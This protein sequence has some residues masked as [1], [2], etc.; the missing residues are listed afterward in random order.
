VVARY[1]M[2]VTADPL[3]T[4]E[5]FAIGG[6]YTVRGYR[7][8]QLVR[9]NG[10][11]GSAEVR[12]P[13]YARAQPRFRIDLIPFFD[14]GHSWNEDR[15]EFGQKTLVSAGLGAR[16]FVTKWGYGELF[17]GHRFRDVTRFGQRDAQDD[18]IHF[19]IAA[20]WP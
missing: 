4:L 17:W 12:V 3:L 18:G 1:D 16:A 11:I 6:R 14:V 20:T 15:P 19:R 10:L 9:D 2:Q 8:N 5:Q 13:I 7:E